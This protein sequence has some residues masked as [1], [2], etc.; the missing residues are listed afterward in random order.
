LHFFR[1]KYLASLHAFS[2]KTEMTHFR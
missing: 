1:K 2:I